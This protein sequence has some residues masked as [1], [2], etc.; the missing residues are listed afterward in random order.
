MPSLKFVALSGTTGVTENC[1][2][3][4]YGDSMIVVDCGV[5]FPDADMYGVDLVIPDFSYVRKNASKL[6]AVIITHGHEDHIGAIPFLLRDV[7]APVYASPLTLGFIKDKLADYGMRN[8]KLNSFNPDHDV[9]N[10]GDFKITPFRVSHSVPD[11]CGLCIETKQ[12]KVFHVPDYKFDWTPVDG[13]PFDVAKAS[14]LASSGVLALASDSLGSTSPGYTESETTIEGI[15]NEIV[16]G[17]T[18]LIYFTTVSS[19]ISRMQQAVDVALKNNRKICFIGRS[20]IR[21]TDIAKKLGYLNYPKHLVVGTAEARKLPKD[22]IMYVISGSYG[23]PGS[24]LYRV[25]MGDHDFLSVSENDTV[26]FSADPAPPGA[27]INVDFLVDRLLEANI[28]VHYYDMQENL[29]VSGHGSQEDIKMLIGITRPKYLIPIG[30]TIRHNRAYAKIAESMGSKRQHILELSG[31]ETVEFSDG[32]AKRGEKIPVKEVLVD[33]LEVGD[34]GQVVLRDRKILASDGIAIVVLTF[35]TAE[36]K[37]GDEAEIISR[38][39]V[40]EKMR[41]NF[42][43][44]S[45]RKLV[46]YLQKRRIINPS[47]AKREAVDYLERYFFE[48]TG[49]RPMVLPVVVEE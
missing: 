29:H 16:S 10:I 27:K 48:Q 33:G 44:E 12:G 13:K 46:T 37:I 24:A 6:K 7:K 1:Y 8:I 22:R 28:D 18:G 5:G 17:A 31:G 4:E 2:L 32:V 42:L 43:N 38:G 45:A 9:L 23:Q 35:D 20:I 40:F 34:V 26:V 21:K 15:I 39:F 47:N 19:N 14:M 11:A 41:K 30:G 25:A 36:K 49:R 3:Y